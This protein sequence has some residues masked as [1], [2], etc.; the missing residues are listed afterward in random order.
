[1]FNSDIQYENIKSQFIVPEIEIILDSTSLKADF[2]FLGNDFGV[3]ISQLKVNN[4]VKYY[5]YDGKDLLPF[6]V[7]PADK[8]FDFYL[9]ENLN[10]FEISKDRDKKYILY[11]KASESFK[12]VGFDLDNRKINITNYIESKG[13]N[14]Y[15]VSEILSENNKYLIYSDSLNNFLTISRIE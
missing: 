7:E 8:K 4:N 9:P 5:S 15:F 2:T 1:M 11:D 6:Y 13:V 12:K 14:G 3:L 10:S